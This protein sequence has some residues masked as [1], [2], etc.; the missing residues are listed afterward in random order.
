MTN[1][2]QIYVSGPYSIEAS[3]PVHINGVTFK[4]G[5]IVDFASGEHRII[6]DYTQ[7]I[8]L[9]WNNT[10]VPDIA[11]PEGNLFHGF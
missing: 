9:R 8:S 2:F 10:K 7:S 5:D 11:A 6:S 1:D 4:R 3:H